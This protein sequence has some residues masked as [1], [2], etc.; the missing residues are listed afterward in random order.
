M[1]ETDLSSATTPSIT[2]EYVWFGGRPIAQLDGPSTIHWTFAD[3]LATPILQTTAT[4]TIDWRVEFEPYGTVYTY[5]AGTSNHQP[6]RFPGQ[7]YDTTGLVKWECN[8]FVGTL[9]AGL[10]AG[11][12]HANCISECFRGQ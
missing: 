4:A 6:L 2:H 12:L 5:R 7:E 1:A 8:V 9:G 11:F 10:A 3:H